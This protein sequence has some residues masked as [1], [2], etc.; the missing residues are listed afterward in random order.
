MERT[1]SLPKQQ[2]LDSKGAYAGNVEPNPEKDI[3]D[4]LAQDAGVSIP[5]GDPINV[6]SMVE[7][8]DEQRWELDPESAQRQE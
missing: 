2:A 5:Q 7:E 8:R 1:D 4:T 6:K 3:V